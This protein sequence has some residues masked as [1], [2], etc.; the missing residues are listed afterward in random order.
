MKENHRRCC[1]IDGHKNSVTVCV[2]APAG[3]RHIAVKKRQFRR[4]TRDLRQLRAWWK[5]CNVTEIAMESTGQYWRALWNLLEGE[6]AK[7]ILVNS[8]T[9]QGTQ[10]V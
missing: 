1:G 3:Q 10:R 2:L 7:L 8:A 6:F 4:Y 9:H 5:N